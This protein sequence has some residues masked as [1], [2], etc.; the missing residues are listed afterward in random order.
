MSNIYVFGS[1]AEK[2][3]DKVT[4]FKST[5]VEQPKKKGNY[6]A[7]YNEGEKQEVYPFR[8][9]EDL[10]KMHEYFV[11]KKMWR[12]DL[13]FILG[14][15]IGLR[16]GDLLELTWGQVFPESRTEV[17]NGITVKEEKTDKWRTF[18]LNES[19]KK[20]IVEYFDFLISD[21]NAKIEKYAK[22]MKSYKARNN[23]Y[24]YNRVKK[25]FDKCNYELENIMD[26]YVFK[27]N[28]GGHVEVRPAGLI[29]KKAS[30]A[31]GITYNVGTH[32][33]RKTFGY[34]QLK[35]HKDDAVFLCELQEMFNHSSPKITLRYCGLEAE[36]MEQY[37]NDVCLL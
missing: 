37:Y 27:S 17:A 11:S 23:M 8:T 7:N 6:K 10:Q 16:A 15:N 21:Y 20:A 1:T 34:W 35:A 18:Y 3:S 31:V 28:K 33:M 29:L 30:Q 36:K 19:C 9:E 24:E 5:P 12:N 32:S 14:I 22:A 26:E 25:Q 2:L 13:M 4:E